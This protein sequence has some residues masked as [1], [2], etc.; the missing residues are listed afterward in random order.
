[1][2]TIN[3]FKRTKEEVYTLTDKIV[4]QIKM[5]NLKEYQKNALIEELLTETKP[6]YT[7]NCCSF[8]TGSHLKAPRS[9]TVLAFDEALYLTTTAILWKAITYYNVEHPVHF[10]KY[11][12][13]LTERELKKEYDAKLNRYNNLD[14]KVVHLDIKAGDDD[15]STDLYNL[16]GTDWEEDHICFEIEFKKALDNF[17]ATTKYGELIKCEFI[18]TKALQTNMRLKILGSTVYGDSERSKVKR[19]KKK[20][21]EYILNNHAGLSDYL[22]D[23]IHM[24]F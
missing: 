20:F 1:M 12:Q 19:V 3:K 23:S 9:K 15:R 17:I 16:V 5:G 18:G 8:F 10:M 24:K 2:T 11:W 14:N 13:V 7:H 22:I 4:E 21:S 6:F